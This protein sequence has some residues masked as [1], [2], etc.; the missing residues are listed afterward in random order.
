MKR[1]SSLD[2]ASSPVRQQSRCYLR[3][4]SWVGCS[5]GLSSH[6]K[7]HGQVAEESG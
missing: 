6:Q 1:L 4:V 2:A 5:D 3:H 7:Q